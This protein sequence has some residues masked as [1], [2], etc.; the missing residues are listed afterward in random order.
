[1]QLSYRPLPSST[2]TTANQ[3]IKTALQKIISLSLVLVF[4]AA[5]IVALPVSVVLVSVAYPIFTFFQHQNATI[6]L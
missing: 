2:Q 6:E 3:L 4:T 5:A 1:M